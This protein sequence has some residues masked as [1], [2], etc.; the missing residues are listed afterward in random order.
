MIRRFAASDRGTVLTETIIAVPL[1]TILAIGMLE[2]GNM[3]WQR[4][5]LQV[6]V[7]DA[8]RYWARCRPT[9]DGTAFMPCS[10][11]IARNLA[12]Y[13]N[14][15]GTGP[16]R[17]PGWDNASEL[18]ITPA[19]PPA[20]PTATSLVTATGN[21]PYQGSPLISVLGLGTI[22]LSYTYTLRYNGW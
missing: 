21:F 10:Q 1:L 11:N 7:R 12:F 6:G 4:H 9:I 8:A 13:G 14:P 19:T 17:V 20:T 15:A 18:T 2:F 16:L 22:R 5:Q 3:L